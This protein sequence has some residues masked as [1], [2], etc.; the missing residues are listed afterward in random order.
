M[1]N[2]RYDA[3][4]TKRRAVTLFTSIMIALV[5]VTI[6]ATQNGAHVTLPTLP[7]SAP[8][9]F[10]RVTSFVDGDTIEVDMNGAREK[11]RFIG[12][13]TPET[14]KPNT[15]VQCFGPE[16]S[17]FTKNAIGTQSVRLEA[18]PKGDNRDRYN[19]LLRYVYLTDG[20]LLNQKVIAEGFGFAYL[21]FPFSKRDEFAQAQADARG[22]NRGL[23]A[24][25]KP[26][27]E[28]TGRWQ[29]NEP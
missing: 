11:V 10:Y 19:R 23:W 2:L 1:T 5:S 8:P 28:K 4:M 29:S 6:F 15:P 20:T 26:I 3:S 27:E 13:D 25:C 12:I 7:A 18:D 14:H 16:A 21:S 17:D 24:R 9:G 22:T